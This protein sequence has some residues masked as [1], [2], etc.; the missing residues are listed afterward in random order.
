MSLSEW[1]Y[2]RSYYV[3]GYWYE[4]TDKRTA[5]YPLVSC[6]PVV[7]A[8]IMY[9][10][11][12][13]MTKLGPEF[14]KNRKPMDLRRTMMFY[15]VTMI[16]INGYYFFQALYRSDYLMRLF[17]FHYPDRNDVRP[18]TMTVSFVTFQQISIQFF[19][20]FSSKLSP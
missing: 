1:L 20:I 15:N 16:A 8:A 5:H 17:D 3:Y 11:Y 6:H 12:I 18:H 2:E 7:I 4:I 13:V 19:L 10:Y 14:M 9:T